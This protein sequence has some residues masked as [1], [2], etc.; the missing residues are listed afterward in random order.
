VVTETGDTRGSQINLKLLMH[1]VEVDVQWVAHR[2]VGSV[3]NRQT[4]SL[5]QCANAMMQEKL[6]EL[7]DHLV[8]LFSQHGW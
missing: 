2:L 7:L 3:M 6:T 8:G 5:W 4:D 1:L